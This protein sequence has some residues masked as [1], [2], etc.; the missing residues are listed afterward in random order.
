M[1]E[2]INNNWVETT[3][4]ILAFVYL[5]LEIKQKWPF[6]IVGIFSSAFYVSI[7]FQA[8]LYA[9]MGL[10]CYYI[11]MCFYGLYCWKFA[12]EVQGKNKSFHHIPVKTLYILLLIFIVLFVSLLFVLNLFPDS[13]VPVPDALIAILSIIATWM[14]AKKIVECWYIW[15]FVN[16]FATG[17]YIYQKL[18]PTAVLFI[19]YSILSFV[20]LMEWRKSV[21]K[22]DTTY[23]KL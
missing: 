8:G 20:G 5:I 10:N 17:L 11:L 15:I 18:Y 4:A 12:T 14:V 23:T 3:G 2:W 19:F 22:N 1:V 7:F 16:S 6:W 13:Q 9:E 21:K